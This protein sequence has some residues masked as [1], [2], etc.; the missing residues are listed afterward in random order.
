[1]GN[2][3]S[4]TTHLAFNRDPQEYRFCAVMSPGVRLG[5]V[6]AKTERQAIAKVED[7]FFGSLFYPNQI[8]VWPVE[9][10]MVIK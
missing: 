10:E 7:S 2:F 9:D 3:Y 5:T 6:M 4:V 1:M 8:Y